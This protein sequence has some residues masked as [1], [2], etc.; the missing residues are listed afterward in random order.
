MPSPS[1]SIPPSPCPFVYG[2]SPGYCF[3]AGVRVG[4]NDLDGTDPG[5]VVGHDLTNDYN[6]SQMLWDPDLSDGFDTGWVSVQLVGKA[7]GG[8]DGVTWTLIQPD[9]TQ[10]TINYSGVTYG[11]IQKVQILASVSAQN[12]KITWS[13][14]A[15]LFYRN[16]EL[17]DTETLDDPCN[18]VADTTGPNGPSSA[19]EVAELD[20]DGANIDT[21]VVTGLVRMQSPNTTLPAPDAITGTIFVFTSNCQTTN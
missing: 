5:A 2:V 7:G 11:P 17:I 16:G 8:N 14:V 15:A 1:S 10:T 13:A 21:V 20:P 19:S 3:A 4:V 9:Q 12:M 6:G 18:P